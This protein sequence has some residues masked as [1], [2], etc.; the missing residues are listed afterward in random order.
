MCTQKTIDG[1][2]SGKLIAVPKWVGIFRYI[3]PIAIIALIFSLGI[4]KQELENRIFKDARERDDTIHEVHLNTQHS[5]SI[6]SHMPF[7]EKVQL[8]VPR[9]E[10]EYKLDNINKNQEKIMKKLNIN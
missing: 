4:W 5:T 6:D 8:F 3:N 1:I 9:T 7:E 2:N 10:I